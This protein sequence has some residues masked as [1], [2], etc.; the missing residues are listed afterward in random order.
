MKKTLC[1]L[2][3]L[4]LAMLTAASVGAMAEIQ[5]IRPGT[6]WDDALLVETNTVYASGPAVVG[7]GV[8]TEP[9]FRFV[10]TERSYVQLWCMNVSAYGRNGFYMSN[11][12]TALLLEKGDSDSI[13]A[14]WGSAPGKPQYSR[15]AILPAGTYFVQI[16]DGTTYGTVVLD[17][18]YQ[19]CVYAYP[20][21][22]GD[23]RSEAKPVSLGVAVTSTIDYDGDYDYFT[24]NTDNHTHYRLTVE[25]LHGK[26]DVD[27]KNYCGID[28]GCFDDEYKGGVLA[29]ADETGSDVIELKPNTK[30]YLSVKSLNYN[31]DLADFDR[32]PYAVRIDPIEEEPTEVPTPEPTA[33]PAPAA[34]K[35]ATVGGLKYSLSGS[36]ATVT[37]PKDKNAAKLTIPA[38]IKANGKT[39]KVIAVKASA[40]KGMKKL[41]ALTIG[42]N[43]RNIG[44]NAFY[45]CKKLQTINIRTKQLTGTTV[46]SNAF[47]GIAAKAKITCPSGK[48]N[49][50]RKLLQKRGVGD[51]ATFK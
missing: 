26:T 30:S 38:T 27:S 28:C 34:A 40:C 24:F 31:A 48:K 25:N 19:F 29:R 50:Y 17:G 6:A 8:Y 42:K 32:I 3:A 39:Y 13:L 33:T 43:V 11:L 35:T 36:K 1:L 47:K 10:L 21:S 14:S 9:M 2:L 20:D 49:A 41:T 18:E 44:K 7:E 15:S 46:A 22:V 45:G 51:K 12:I 23:N 37:G 4:L 16:H 5:Q